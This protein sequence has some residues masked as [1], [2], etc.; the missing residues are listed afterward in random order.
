MA[1]DKLWTVV[2]DKLCQDCQSDVAD[3]HL[4]CPRSRRRS[5]AA[6]SQWSIETVLK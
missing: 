1:A 2:A 5:D 6:C 4:G 3:S